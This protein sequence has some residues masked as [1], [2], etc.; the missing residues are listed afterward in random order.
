MLPTC[1][2]S[3]IFYILLHS[4]NSTTTPV[5]RQGC[6]P[7]EKDEKSRADTAFQ[8]WSALEGFVCESLPRNVRRRAR[9]TG[10]APEHRLCAW[11]AVR[12]T[13]QNEKALESVRI[14]RIV[15]LWQGKNVFYEESVLQRRS[16]GTKNVFNAIKGHKGLCVNTHWRSM[17][18]SS[19]HAVVAFCL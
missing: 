5:F 6:N 12:Q 10:S 18:P 8:R 13:L 17:P 9:G 19:P 1:F 15:V 3:C 11:L 2:L 7:L 16:T 4:Q 14:K